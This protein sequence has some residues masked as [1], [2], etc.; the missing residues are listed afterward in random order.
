MA[1][2]QVAALIW[3][4]F[5]DE[6]SA[7]EAA[8]SLLDRKLVA[9]ANILPSMTSL[10][11]WEG[12]RSESGEVG[13]IFK[14]TQAGFDAAIA[15]LDAHHPYDNPAILGWHADAATPA[16]LAWLSAIVTTE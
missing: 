16:T 5:P 7:R 8:G 1:G 11:L 9:C 6:A 4:P 13:V 2:A 10:F 14:T 12:K 3:C 15:A